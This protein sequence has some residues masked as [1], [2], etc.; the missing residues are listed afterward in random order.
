MWQWEQKTLLL[1][2][3]TRETLFFCHGSFFGTNLCIV[4]MRRIYILKYNLTVSTFF[5]YIL[6]Q[7]Q[8]FL[9]QNH[10]ETCKQNW[11]KFD[12]TTNKYQYI[13]DNVKKGF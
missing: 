1:H 4:Y 12:L 3:N 11:I 2:W 13:R 5:Q 8:L 10:Y 9:I 7:E 6:N